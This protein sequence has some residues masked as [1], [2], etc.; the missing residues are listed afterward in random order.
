MKAG[1]LTAVLFLGLLSNSVAQLPLIRSEDIGKPVTEF[2]HY[3][4]YATIENKGLNEIWTFY[5]NGY[6]FPP[7]ENKR[8]RYYFHQANSYIPFADTL[9]LVAIDFTF[10][11]YDSLEILNTLNQFTQIVHDNGN[12][13]F[14][15]DLV[16]GGAWPGVSGPT[17]NLHKV[18]KT[19]VPHLIPDPYDRLHHS[20][21]LIVSFYSDEDDEFYVKLNF[22][23]KTTEYIVSG[24]S[25]TVKDAL[26][27]E[28]IELLIKEES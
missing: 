12:R 18:Y 8:M 27:Q 17:S 25:P 13:Y 6:D 9:T 1:I 16:N 28:L 20:G 24:S 7:V 26:L 11:S 10:R 2:E 19:S 15:A 4:Q 14:Y 5:V 23:P 22:Y 21:T 3:K